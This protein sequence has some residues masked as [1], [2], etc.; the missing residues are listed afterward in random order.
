[1]VL[2]VIFIFILF[3]S[4]VWLL[5]VLVRCSLFL[6]CRGRGG[7]CAGKEG[8]GGMHE[9]DVAGIVLYHRLPPPPSSVCLG[10]CVGCV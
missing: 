3:W 7:G 9:L 2:G 8:R 5:L 1:V 6:C 4:F 10:V